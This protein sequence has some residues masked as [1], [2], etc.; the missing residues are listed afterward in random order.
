MGF[1]LTGIGSVA[2][3]AKTIANKFFPDKMGD[4]E[5]AKAEIELQQILA[6]R[7]EKMAE[8]KKAVMVAE[9]N[10]AD[11]YTKRARPTIIYAGLFFI[12]LVH[13][14]FPI[15]FVMFG[16][17][18]P[19]LTLPEQFWWAW[20]GVCSVYAIGRSAEKGGAK[21]KLVGMITGNK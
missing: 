10:Q 21:N 12:F 19:E 9:L 11:R 7:D 2:D 15:A 3:A 20:G 17:K 8:S 1:D 16:K 13:V 14:F 6:E 5:R 18:L 4:G